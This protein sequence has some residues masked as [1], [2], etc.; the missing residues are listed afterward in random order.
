MRRSSDVATRLVV[1]KVPMMPRISISRRN[2]RMIWVRIL[3]VGIVSRL[4]KTAPALGSDRIR[5]VEEDQLVG[6]AV[7]GREAIGDHGVGARIPR[8]N[9]DRS[10]RVHRSVALAVYPDPLIEDPSAG[11]IGREASGRGHGS[12][13]APVLVVAGLRRLRN[14]LAG[15]NDRKPCGGC[16]GWGR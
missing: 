15:G 7:L 6:A 12:L 13:A 5:R 14:P 3:R 10:L 9:P 1:K 2:G 16:W 4:A 8:G 11:A